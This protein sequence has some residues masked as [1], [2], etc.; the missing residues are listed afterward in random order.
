MFYAPLKIFSLTWRCHHYRWRA[1]NFGLCSALRACEQGWIFIVP[2]LLWN[3]ASVFPVSSEGP[4]YS[5]TSYDSQG[6]RRTYS[7]PDLHGSPFSRLLR[8][9]RGC[10]GPVL[11]W[12]LTGVV[13]F[14]KTY[15]WVRK[16]TVFLKSLRFKKISGLVATTALFFFFYK[17]PLIY[18][19]AVSVVG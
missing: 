17:T 12:I 10:W 13:A 11:T 5:V 7:N 8:H 18:G 3:G 4:P 2:H 19:A 14:E 16:S 1:A 6:I 9:A 15:S